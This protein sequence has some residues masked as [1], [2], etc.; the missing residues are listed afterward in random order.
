[1]STEDKPN[2]TAA[3][4][5]PATIEPSTTAKTTALDKLAAKLTDI[6]SKAEYNEM[7]GVELVAPTEGYADSLPH[8][9]RPQACNQPN[10][11]TTAKTSP[12]PPP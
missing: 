4:D 1:M 7:Y 5:V 12:S 9:L 8:P 3:S 10:V 2:E 11:P 6:I